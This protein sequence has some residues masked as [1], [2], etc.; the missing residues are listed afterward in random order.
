M[1]GLLYDPRSAR[2]G[3]LRYHAC[4]ACVHGL[5][6]P[7][8]CDVRQ[9]RLADR[10]GPD[11]RRQPGQSVSQPHAARLSAE[12][13]QT[14]CLRA[15]TYGSISTWHNIA[16][17]GTPSG[18]IT[19]TPYPGEHAKVVGWVDVE[20]SY[21]TISGLE[22][23]GSNNFYDQERAGTNCP[24]PV[25]QGLTING[26]NDT[27]EDND[28]YQS[29]ASLRGDGI[30]IGWGGE[31]NNTIIRDNKI[32][33]VGQCEDYD[34]IIYLAKGQN[35]QIS[36]NWLWNDPHG[37]GIQVY[38]GA[39]GA[40]IFDNVIDSAGSGFTVGGSSATSGNQITH[41]VVLNSTGLPR[42]N[43]QGVAISD[44]WE[45]APGT[46]N[47]FTDN[48]SYRNPNGIS[49]VT[50]VHTSGNISDAP[51]FA[52]TAAHDYQVDPGSPVAGWGLWNGAQQGASQSATA[53]STSV[54]PGS[55]N[56]VAHAAVLHGN[57]RGRAKR[58][59]H[60]HKHKVRTFE[61]RVK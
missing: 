59:R 12:P 25:S 20:A 54:H 11:R 33:D 31:A 45:G 18:Q 24:Y 19:I 2:A 22:I 34:Q 29:V 41:N 27:F 26:S 51:D 3:R 17:N 43:L 40:H 30:G 46:S 4:A 52:D 13:G 10:I 38:P 53:T 6:E 61:L 5:R 36:N 47:N 16:T 1:H 9:V 50:A 48:D 44:Y 35:V 8:G 21:T 49:R 58:R 14:G 55:T 57:G 7:R 42:A 37:W 32:H 23:D 15:G 28:Y 39:S 56:P 60:H